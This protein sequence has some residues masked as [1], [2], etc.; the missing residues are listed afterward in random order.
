M[1]DR[2]VEHDRE[3]IF[4]I[5]QRFYCRRGE[6]YTLCHFCL[7]ATLHVNGVWSVIDPSVSSADSYQSTDVMFMSKANRLE[8]L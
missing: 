7:R 1:E 4:F 8:I 3:I 6:D 2:D 5:L